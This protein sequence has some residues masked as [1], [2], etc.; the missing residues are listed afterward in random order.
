VRHDR[1]PFNIVV[2]V[3]FVFVGGRIR[4]ATLNS[5]KCGQ[6]GQEFLSFF[7]F[8]LLA[9]PI[10]A[11]NPDFQ[12]PTE[13]QVAEMEGSCPREASAAPFERTCKET[14]ALR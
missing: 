11:K 7:S 13:E 5:I 14:M 8:R 4:P 10:A 6:T 9:I 1:T 12:P 2:L 3:V